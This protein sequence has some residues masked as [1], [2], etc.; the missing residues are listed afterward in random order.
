MMEEM[1]TVYSGVENDPNEL[2]RL[3]TNYLSIL[4]G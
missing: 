4:H 1:I 3:D 2:G